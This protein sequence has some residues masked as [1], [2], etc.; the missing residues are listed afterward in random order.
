MLIKPFTFTGSALHLNASTSATGSIQV[1]VQ[2]ED[3][4][5]LDPVFLSA[6][7]TDRQSCAFPQVA[8]LAL[9]L[10]G[11]PW[12][13]AATDAWAEMAVYSVGLPAT[14]LIP[15]GVLAEIYNI[16]EIKHVDEIAT[17]RSVGGIADSVE[18]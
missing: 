13:R 7:G 15:S 2:H 16:K 11:R 17:D 10:P 18:G 1:E 3:A 6:P 9:R 8:A 5:I 12:P 4:H 14:A